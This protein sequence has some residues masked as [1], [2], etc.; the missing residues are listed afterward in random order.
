MK[1]RKTPVTNN[2]IVQKLWKMADVLRDDG[3][4][5][6]NYVTELTYILFLKMMKEQGTESAI[7]EG[8]HWD[9][10]LAKEG[11]KLK[12][13]YKQLLLDLGNPEIAKDNRLNMIYDDASTS[14]DEPANLEKIIKDIDALDWY[15][16]KH[17][18]LGDLYEGLLE[19]NA[20]ETKSGAGQYFTPRILID[21]MVQLTRPELGEKLNDPAAGTFGFMIAADHYLK[22]KYDQFFDLTPEQVKFQKKEALSGMELVQNTHR[23][24]LMN[25]LLHDIEGQL[26]QGDSLS[27]NGKWMK[28][29][30]VVLTNPPFGTK[31]G[32]ER[33]TRDDLTYETSNKQLNFLQT[34]YNSLKTTGK[35]RAAVVVPDNVLFA[36]NVGEQIRKDLLNKC[37]LHT[38]LR[39]PTGIFYAQGVQTNVLFFGRGASEK[40]NTKETWIYDMRSNMRSLGKRSPFRKD[41]FKEF[42]ECFNLD[43][44]TQRQETWSLENTN[45]RWRKYSIE[46][47]RKRANTNLD[48]FWMEAEKDGPAYSISELLDLMEQKSTAI[49]ES[50]TKLQELLGDVSE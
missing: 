17:E 11:L 20:N 48:I 25:A 29:Y 1:R 34:I 50:I 14:I 30:D 36:D 8:Y 7:P 6:Q 16:A 43:N 15:S 27:T 47:I 42:I 44:L 26:E 37:N 46:D 12:T 19:K 10:L 24:A 18:G 5:Y 31:K 49:S 9:D 45:G 22:E 21:V 33:A 3:I 38:I 28:G 2:E 23:L 39:L 41:D 13:F 35:A 4:S 32:G 40:E